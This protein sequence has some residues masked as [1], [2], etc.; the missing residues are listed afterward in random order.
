M[1]LT[2]D[3]FR[4]W[5]KNQDL[6][7]P[8]THLLQGANDANLDEATKYSPQGI[9]GCNFQYCK[10]T[11]GGSYVPLSLHTGL[12]LEKLRDSG[13]WVILKIGDLDLGDN[14]LARS[15]RVLFL[16]N[17]ALKYYFRYN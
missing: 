6:K 10:Y 8:L 11:V 4:Q 16:S 14:I 2:S 3:S 17:K 9:F 7:L 12:P 1:N 5:Y 15:T 13:F